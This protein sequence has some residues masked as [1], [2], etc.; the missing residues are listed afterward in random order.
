MQF[1]KKEPHMIKAELKTI[2]LKEGIEAS[3][4]DDIIHD[5]ASKQATDANN[6]GIEG[7]IN[8]LLDTCE[9]TPQNILDA[10]EIK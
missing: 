7:Q 9:W 2:F 4:L 8:Y 1:P 6:G 5:A 3:S 10:L